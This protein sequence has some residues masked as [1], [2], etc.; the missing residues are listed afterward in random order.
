MVSAEL[1]VE[2]GAKERII[3]LF[4][5][6]REERKFN[7]CPLTTFIQQIFVSITLSKYTLT[8]IFCIFVHT[9]LL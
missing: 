3:F 8:L 6:N 9:S 2:Q 7:T 5:E 4:Y 1:C